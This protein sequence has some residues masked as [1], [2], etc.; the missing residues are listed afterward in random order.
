MQNNFQLVEI[1]DSAAVAAAIL[2]PTLC[3]EMLG[4]ILIL[5][6]QCRVTSSPLLIKPLCYQKFKRLKNLTIKRPSV[7]R[8]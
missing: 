2:P 7:T 4:C 5:L 3:S 8:F 6:G 1:Y